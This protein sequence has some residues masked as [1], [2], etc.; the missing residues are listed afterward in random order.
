MNVRRRRGRKENFVASTR[1]K[2]K[3]G[4]PG[5]TMGDDSYLH[6]HVE[7][8]RMEKKEK[9]SLLASNYVDVVAV[10]FFLFMVSWH[11]K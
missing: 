4:T 1:G 7:N 3:G 9:H 8:R 10:I 2:K 5:R 11:L 6:W